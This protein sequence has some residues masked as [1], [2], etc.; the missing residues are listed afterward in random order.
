MLRV[1]GRKGAQGEVYATLKA[2]GLK[3]SRPALQVRGLCRATANHT[4]QAEAYATKVVR[5]V[6]FLNLL[7]GPSRERARWGVIL[8]GDRLAG[9]YLGVNLYN[10]QYWGRGWGR[11][12]TGPAD[13]YRAMGRPLVQGTEKVRQP[14]LEVPIPTQVW[15]KCHK[16]QDIPRLTKYISRGKLQRP[17]I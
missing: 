17:R 10:V 6:F 2:A 3:N 13:L 4:A 7:G 15:G 16:M 12:K 11:D 14:F 1:D 9:G 5:V 8:Y